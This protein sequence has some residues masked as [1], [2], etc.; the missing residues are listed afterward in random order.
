MAF[1]H[2]F[3]AISG[4]DDEY[5]EY[6]V[7]QTDID[8]S[9]SPQGNQYYEETSIASINEIGVAEA[10]NIVTSIAFLIAFA[11]LRIQ[12]VN[13]IAYFPKW[14]LKGLRTSSIQTGG[15][16]SKFINLDFMSYV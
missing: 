2:A 16:G 4:S 9:C 6:G 11:I 1:D 13:D 14:Y 3:Y 7:Y 5:D 12:P 8:T 15:F 10:I